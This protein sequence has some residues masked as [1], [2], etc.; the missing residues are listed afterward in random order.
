MFHH[1][2]VL[3]LGR[4]KKNSVAQTDIIGSLPK[5]L[6]AMLHSAVLAAE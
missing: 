4:L 2:S 6:Y 1:N 3:P 5:I